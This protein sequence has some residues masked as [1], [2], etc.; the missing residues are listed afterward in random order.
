M[1]SILEVSGLAFLAVLALVV[2][3]LLVAAVAQRSR[4]EGGGR[5]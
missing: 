5:A 2:V 4:G 1:Q 3:A